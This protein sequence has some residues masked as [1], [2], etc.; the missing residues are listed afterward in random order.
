[1]AKRKGDVELLPLG[2]SSEQL[3]SNVMQDIHDICTCNFCPVVGSL[4]EY[5][6]CCKWAKC[7]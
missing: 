1:M 5:S 7:L 3:L 4:S 2:I 6:F